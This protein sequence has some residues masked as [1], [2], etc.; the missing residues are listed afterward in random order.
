MKRIKE[1]LL[2][3]LLLVTLPAQA[4]VFHV[5]KTADT[6]DGV[7]DEDCSLR[8]AVV[9]ANALPGK[10]FVLAG[11]GVYTLGRPGRF[12]EAGATGDLDVRGSLVLL[13]A[14]ADRTVLDGGGL[15]RV[16]DVLLLQPF[17]LQGVTVRNG[18]ATGEHGG[19][20]RAEGTLIV[21]NSL[22]S[23]SSTDGYGGGI[24]AQDLDL[25]DSTVS[26]ND[27]FWG[28]GLFV[29]HGLTLENVTVSG[30]HAEVG[31]GLAYTADHTSFMQMTVTGNSAGTG[32]GLAHVGD[33]NCP[34]GCQVEHVLARSVVAG[35]SAEQGVDCSGG[36]TGGYNV[37]GVGED[38]DVGPTDRAGTAAHPL[39]ARL[40]PLGDHG[41]PTPTHSLLAGSPALDLAPAGS[42]PAADQRG[43]PR[44]VDGD[45][46]GAP[47]CDAGALEAIPGCEPEPSE[48]PA[49]CLGNRFRVSVR[50]AAQ[51]DEGAGHALPLAADTGAFWFFGPDNLEMMVKVLNGCGLNQR[52]WV[53]LSGLTD[54]E[55]DVTV[56]D[57]IT[58]E[59][60]EHHHAGGS[61]LPTRLDTGALAVCSAAGPAIGGT[62]ISSPLPGSVQR[63]TRTADT[64][65]GVCDRDCSL[66]EAVFAGNQTVGG[67]AVV[68]GPGVYT[69]T[70]AGRGEESSATGDLDVQG[71]LVILGAG[72]ESTILDGGG[73]DRVLDVRPMGSLEVHDVT[74]RNGYARQIGGD[75]GAGGGIQAEGPLTV[76]RSLV[77]GNRAETTGG[78]IDDFGRLTVRDSTIADNSAQSGGGLHDYRQDGLSSKLRLTNVTISGNRAEYAGGASVDHKDTEIDQITVTGNLATR[79]WGGF[80]R[81]ECG[82]IP[83]DPDCC[84]SSHFGLSRSLIA[85]NTAGQAAPDCEILANEGGLNVFGTVNNCHPGPTDLA[86]TDAAPLDPRLSPLGDNGGPTPTHMPLPGSPAIDFAEESC[87]VTRD[88]RGAPR[89]PGGG[90][91]Q[92]CDA[93]AVEASAICLPG[94]TRLCLQDGRFAVTVRWTAQGSSGTGRTVPLT[95]DTGAFWFFDPANLE[96]TVKVLDGCSLDGHYWVFVSGLTDVAV[97]IAV[98]DTRTGNTW[99]H[100]HA[101]GTPLQPRLDTDALECVQP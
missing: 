55:V 45:R 54:V 33:Q 12:E 23:G 95:A 25:R 66:R 93:G 92:A 1:I 43:S 79:Y 44:A 52:F 89:P 72:A 96:M 86:G 50:W 94:P 42:C 90:A 6:L 40:S 84:G 73:I 71:S 62:P 67:A 81:N 21:R 41:G 16:L 64:F 5:T 69:L 65:D 59:T 46:D 61:A 74:V 3:I 14:G 37:F 49:L 2:P 100:S 32:G 60:W 36:R 63:V 51:G 75:F 20:I 24:A 31:G 39:D 9:A 97:E 68:V 38:C 10:D 101:A 28:G 34:G 91:I 48:D 17:E 22:I 57:S 53:F 30:N 19:G 26:G 29:F 15:D 76:V 7:C 13:G 56:E 8:E 99:T 87:P 11:P 88:Q 35:N 82:C 70:R 98:E 58:G 78:G 47:Q 85:G 4:A 27:A 83:E 80:L 18:H 77:T